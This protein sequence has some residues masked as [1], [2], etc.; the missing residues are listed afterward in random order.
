[1]TDLALRSR[2][3]CH[4]GEVRFYAHPSVEIGG[5]M[6]FAVFVP[7]QAAQQA[8]PVLF[9]LAG[10]TCNEETFTTKAAALGPAAELGVMLVAPD[11]SPRDRRYPGDDESWDFGLGAGF[12]LDATAMPWRQSYRMHA[13]VTREL[14]ELIARHLPGRRDRF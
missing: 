7:A 4:G 14:P 8:V 3:R 9:Y 1:M 11:T 6:R 10:L 5:E 2:H 12:Y 13:Y